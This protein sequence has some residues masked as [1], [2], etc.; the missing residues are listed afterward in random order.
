MDRKS[1]W[2]DGGM[3]AWMDL[4]TALR[5]ACSKKLYDQVDRQV[6]KRS[7]SRELK[8]ERQM[9]CYA[10]H[11]SL[12]RAAIYCGTLWVPLPLSRPFSL[13]FLLFCTQFGLTCLFGWMFDSTR[14]SRGMALFAAFYCARLGL[15][16][17]LHSRCRRDA[18]RAVL[19]QGGQK[20]LQTNTL[21]HPLNGCRIIFCQPKAIRRPN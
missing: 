19:V 12:W 9:E 18:I 21:P 15:T 17:R 8:R 1:L 14:R 16:A 3:V 5:I 10:T 6:R 7:W 4:K 11:L 2:V 20:M 13:S